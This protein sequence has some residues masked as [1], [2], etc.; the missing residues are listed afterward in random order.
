MGR[1]FFSWFILFLALSAPLRGTLEEISKQDWKQINA[2]RIPEGH[3]A[4]Q[5]LDQ[6]C[7]SARVFANLDAM[8][9]AGFAN[10]KPQHH[11]RIIVTRHPDLPGYVIKAYL[12]DQAYH[13]EQPEYY[14]WLKR[15]E[16]SRRI[17]KTIDENNFGHLLKV[18]R[19]WIYQLPENPAAQEGTLAKHFILVEDDMNIVGRKKNIRMWRRCA[20]E[21]LLYALKVVMLKDR[22]HDCAKPANCPFSVDGRVALVD[23]QSFDKS[24]VKFFKLNKALSQPMQQFWFS[25]TDQQ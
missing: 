20:T 17:Q 19:K 3:P 21:E 9:A 18:P 12:D 4:K 8:R 14:Y 6:I 5:K 24:H 7:S 1:R 10:A 16:G 23:T 11:T 15:V 2:Y 25:I 22:F 13:S